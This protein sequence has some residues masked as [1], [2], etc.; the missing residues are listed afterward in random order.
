[1]IRFCEPFGGRGRTLAGA[2]LGFCGGNDGTQCG[3]ERRRCIERFER[4]DS[5]NVTDRQCEGGAI[6]AF[7]V[8]RGLAGGGIECEGTEQI[9][10]AVGSEGIGQGLF[11]G[12]GEFQFIQ[13]QDGGIM[14]CPLDDVDRIEL[15]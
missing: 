12:V 9:S 15:R 11:F 3:S 6:D 7:L 8:G 4:V 5:G 14:E 13:V 10:G 2:R 1:M